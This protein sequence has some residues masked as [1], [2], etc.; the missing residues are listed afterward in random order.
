[1]FMSLYRARYFAGTM[2]ALNQYKQPAK[3]TEHRLQGLKTPVM[4]LLGH[5][6]LSRHQGSNVHNSF[7]HAGMSVDS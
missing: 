2:Q 3:D 5:R 1:M 6:N 7:A 4:K